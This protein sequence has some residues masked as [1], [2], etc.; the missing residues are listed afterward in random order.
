M[1]HLDGPGELKHLDD[2]LAIPGLKALQWI[3]GGQNPPSS[4]YPE[5]YEKT[6]AAG[7]SYWVCGSCDDFFSIY[8][9][10]GGRPFFR[11]DCDA[12]DNENADK[13]KSLIS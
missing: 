11:Y 9:N 4:T 6:V 10:A 8:S 13:L 12:A 3:P 7:K 5:V 1:Y 2:I